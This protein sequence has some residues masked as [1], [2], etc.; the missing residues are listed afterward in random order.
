M[1]T[2]LQLEVHGV[3]ASAYLD[4]LIAGNLEK[5][6]KR[7]GPATSCRVVVRAPN[8]HHKSGEPFEVTLRLA[9]SAHR[10]INVGH[11]TGGDKRLADLTFAVNNAFKRALRQLDD[12]TEKLQRRVKHHAA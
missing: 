2:P 4:E 3:K 7:F 6:E 10:E 11:A 12:A 9:L 8:A 1:E 5:I